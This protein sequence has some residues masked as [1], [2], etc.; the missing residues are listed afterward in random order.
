MEFL[1]FKEKMLKCLQLQDELNSKIN[2]DWKDV[3]TEK[4]FY[5]AIWLEAA[6][7]ME[8]LP[9]KWWKKTEI[10]YD[11]LQ[12]EAVD[13]FHFLL[14]LTLLK[15][16][17]WKKSGL[18]Q[19]I[20]YT[21]VMIP[22][23]YLVLKVSNRFNIDELIVK[24]EEL[25]EQSLLKKDT[26][27]FLRFAEIV[28]TVFE[29]FNQMYLLYVGKNILNH[30]RQEYGYNTGTYKKVINGLEDNKYLIQVIKQVQSEKELEK[31]IRK[32]FDVD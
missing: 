16:Y 24:V 21:D 2:K 8:E 22:F 7:L 9:W 30:I 19:S 11:N 13:I 6:E 32:A 23:F 27:M 20:S 10:D 25:A 29:D 15:D 4:D 1:E 3:R 28:K 14:S 12:L 26:A 31:V 18:D 5:R 17:K